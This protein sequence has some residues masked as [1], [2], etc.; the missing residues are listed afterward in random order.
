MPLVPRTRLY[1]TGAPF[2]W[3]EPG[4]GRAGDGARS[5]LRFSSYRKRV[6]H[7]PALSLYRLSC[8]LHV[9]GTQ[10]LEEGPSESAG[11]G[12]AGQLSVAGVRVHVTR[13]GH[14]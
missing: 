13:G 2:A 10:D 4:A 1:R 6:L 3:A 11:W 8:V 12:P 9:L 5:S 7:S 14:S